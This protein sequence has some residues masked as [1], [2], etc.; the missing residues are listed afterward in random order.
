MNTENHAQVLEDM[1]VLA[2]AAARHVEAWDARDTTT[3]EGSAAAYAELA[4]AVTRLER[5]AS[6]VDAIRFPLAERLVSH[7]TD[8][9]DTLSELHAGLGPKPEND[10]LVGAESEA[11][12]EAARRRIGGQP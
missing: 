7:R 12:A 8:Q 4:R 6:T 1:A 9:A 5:L 11:R 10:A 2:E 3:K